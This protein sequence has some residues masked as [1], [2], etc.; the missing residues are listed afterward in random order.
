[1]GGF[2][3]GKSRGVPDSQVREPPVYSGLRDNPL[4]KAGPP[5][6]RGLGETE[7][8]GLPT[9][10]GQSVKLFFFLKKIY[11]SEREGESWEGGE[12]ENLQ[13]DSPL[14]TEPD[15]GLHLMTLRS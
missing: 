14:S 1:M 15:S 7:P 9:F 10:L 6:R 5:L 13:A 4:G 11:L 12:G 2:P 8:L 3:A